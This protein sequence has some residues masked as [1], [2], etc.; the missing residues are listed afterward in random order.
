VSDGKSDAKKAWT[1]GTE[2]ERNR[3]NEAIVRNWRPTVSDRT[4]QH[5]RVKETD[6]T[7]S[8]TTTTVTLTPIQQPEF[9]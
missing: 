4:V 7:T 6:L 8:T 9:R 5:T 1:G 2:W 3:M